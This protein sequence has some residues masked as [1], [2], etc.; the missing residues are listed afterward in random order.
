MSTVFERRVHRLGTHRVV[1]PAGAMPQSAWQLDNTP[2]A[3]AEN[4]I[5]CDVETLSHRFG[6][7]SKQ[8]ADQNADGDCR[9]AS[10]RTLWARSS[11]GAAKPAQSG[12]RQ[13]GGMFVGLSPARSAS[14]CASRG[15]DLKA[16]EPHPASLVSL[17]LTPLHVE[18]VTR[19]D[20]LQPDAFLD[21]RSSDS[22]L[23]SALWAKLP[24]DIDQ[25]RRPGG[26]R[27]RRRAC[28]RSLRLCSPGQT[29]AIVGADGKSRG[30]CLR[31]G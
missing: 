20:V 9:I 22:F 21:T 25:K 13:G 12:N 23:E 8:I 15:I 4:E 28:D 7:R 5:L 29:V 30:S 3:L 24:C 10:P 16:G 26:S 27:R 17:T 18:A 14:R 2:V 19:V 11:R 31:S 6:C 1:E